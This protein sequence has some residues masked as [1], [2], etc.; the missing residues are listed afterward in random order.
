MSRSVDLLDI[1]DKEV[2]YI[3]WKELKVESEILI[4]VCNNDW[5]WY[6]SRNN[7]YL[8]ESDVFDAE[9]EAIEALLGNVIQMKKESLLYFAKKERELI[10]LLSDN[11]LEVVV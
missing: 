11:K 5:Y 1:I 9:K 2:Y 7:V 10:E 8:I 3:N 6:S 4:P